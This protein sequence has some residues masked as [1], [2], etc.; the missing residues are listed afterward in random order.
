MHARKARESNDKALNV[1]RNSLLFW[2]KPLKL[3]LWNHLDQILSIWNKSWVNLWLF[4][5]ENW[6]LTTES[7]M[8]TIEIENDAGI[9]EIERN[10]DSNIQLCCS[11]LQDTLKPDVLTTRQRVTLPVLGFI[12]TDPEP[13]LHT[14][15][16]HYGCRGDAAVL[17]LPR[18]AGDVMRSVLLE[19]ILL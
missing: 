19:V 8:I 1:I 9:N 16:S 10:S 2:N 11:V 18:S 6:I 14:R 5:K 15:G 13:L 17:F 7:Q 4:W 3:A 12:P